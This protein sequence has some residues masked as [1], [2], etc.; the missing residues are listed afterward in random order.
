MDILITQLLSDWKPTAQK[1]LYR[2]L[3]GE[4]R[5]RIS[6]GEIC[7]GA[8]LP[9]SRTL[10]KGLGISRNTVNQA[11]EMLVAD[12]FLCSRPGAGFYVSTDLDV[13][14]LQTVKL[15]E[16]SDMQLGEISQRA[17]KWMGVYRH[18]RVGSNAAAFSPGKPALDEFPFDIWARLLSRRWRMSGPKLGMEETSKGYLPL[19]QHIARHLATTRGC[20]CEAEDII[21]VSG[22]QQGLDLIGRVLW[23]E[24][25]VVVTDDPAFPGISGVLAGVGVMHLPVPIDEEGMKIADL[26]KEYAP[27]SFLVTP[28]RNYPVGVTMSLVR[29]L[30]LLKTAREHK[31]WVV[32]DDFDCDFRFDGQPLS[33]LQSIDRDGR[34]IYVGTFSRILF[35]TLRLGFVVVPKSVTPAFEAAKAYID[36]HASIVHQAALADF[37]EEGYF[38]SHLR[39]MKKLYAARRNH[40][41]DRLEQEFKDYL[42]VMP[43]DGGLHLCVTFKHPCDDVGFA[44]NLSKD[45]VTVRPLSP[46]YKNKN[47][48]SGMVMGFA[49]YT[50]LQLDQGLEVIKKHLHL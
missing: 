13:Q 11:F 41:I 28:S 30:E 36:G 16:N 50:E 47:T 31:A 34:V 1:P 27:K 29:R 26:P 46:F 6:A 19:R 8:S 22:A 15:E 48:P 9:P 35:P 23:D 25:D 39:R 12:G 14:F 5:D 37:F 4:L 18:K 24:D 49:G 21:I 32:E 7:P 2:S 44:K 45:G 3:Y 17:K 20:L 40:L 43:S 42:D 10:S 38:D 33:S